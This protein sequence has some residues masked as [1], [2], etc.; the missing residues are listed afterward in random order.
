MSVHIL[1]TFLW[2]IVQHSSVQ[3]SQCN[4]NQAQGTVFCSLSF[5]ILIKL[6]FVVVSRTCNSSLSCAPYLRRVRCGYFINSAPQCDSILLMW[7][8][9]ALVGSLTNFRDNK[10]LTSAAVVSKL[11]R[12]DHDCSSKKMFKSA[13]FGGPRHMFGNG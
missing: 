4:V 2:L 5:K 8:V 10:R 13:V 3:F 6:C 7:I 1:L 12:C 9:K 11:N